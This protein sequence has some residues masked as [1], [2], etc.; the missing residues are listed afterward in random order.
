MKHFGN[1][2][3]TEIS[4]YR[5]G[6]VTIRGYFCIVEGKKK[7]IPKTLKKKKKNENGP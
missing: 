1:N 3:V 6:Y 2:N 5:N 4:H 7:N